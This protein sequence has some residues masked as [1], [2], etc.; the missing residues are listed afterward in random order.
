M[1]LDDIELIQKRT[2][3]QLP[4][5]YVDIVTNYPVEL[6]ETDAQDFGLLDDADEIIEENNTVRKEGYFGE[7]W[8]EHYFIIGQNG[9]GDY[10][11]TNLNS[12]EFS[13]G[14]ADHE[15]MSCNLYAEGLSEFIEKYTSEQE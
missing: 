13:V 6:L 9:C 4:P 7:K 15:S 1:T 8:P 11:V 5:C 2:N 12:T 10:Y 3:I 14:F